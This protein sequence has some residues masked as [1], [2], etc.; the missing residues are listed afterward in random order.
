MR[1]VFQ[2]LLSETFQLSHDS[3]KCECINF[4]KGNKWPKYQLSKHLDKEQPKTF[5][6]ITKRNLKQLDLA[7]L[8]NCSTNIFVM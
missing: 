5:F 8:R 2:R 4:L 6:I 3:S 1:E 7:A